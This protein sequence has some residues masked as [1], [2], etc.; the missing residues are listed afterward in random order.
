VFDTYQATII[1]NGSLTIEKTEG[2][3]FWNFWSSL[4]N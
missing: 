4:F 1:P 3:D 2:S